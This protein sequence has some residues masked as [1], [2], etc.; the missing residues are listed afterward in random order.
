MSAKRCER[1]LRWHEVPSPLG[2]PQSACTDH[3]FFPF[4]DYALRLVA[5]GPLPVVASQRNTQDGNR[6][7]KPVRAHESESCPYTN[8]VPGCSTG[9]GNR[10][11]KTLCL[12]QIRICSVTPAKMPPMRFELTMDLGPAR[13]LSP[14][15]IPLLLQRH[16]SSKLHFS[17][18]IG[19]TV[20]HICP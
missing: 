1:D 15:H 7:R 13:V 5:T 4:G 19:S 14:A 18:Y 20:R 10:T 11:P 8:F 3:R 6:T 17:L 16:N 2:N 9:A 12:K